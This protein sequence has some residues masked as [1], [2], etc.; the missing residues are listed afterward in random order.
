[1]KRD[2]SLS[3]VG[4]SG[5]PRKPIELMMTPMID[6]IF[7][8]L[9]FFLTTS[10]FQII[11]QLLP[12]AVSQ[13]STPSGNSPK[14]LQ[15]PTQDALDQI[16]VKLRM[17]Q[18]AVSATVNG[19]ALDNLTDLRDRLQAISQLRADVPVVIDP[20]GEVL[21]QTVVLAYDWARQ[22]GLTRVYMAIRK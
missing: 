11:E 7:L 5:R 19:I 9:V 1:M 17:Q 6:V 12:S 14:P 13:S 8:L 3:P 20:E 18:S 15:E 2:F 10:S 4:R 21:A 16:V 22:A